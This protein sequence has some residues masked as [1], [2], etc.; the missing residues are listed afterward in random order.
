MFYKYFYISYTYLNKF[1]S[2]NYY[3]YYFQIF[4]NFNLFMKELN[5]YSKNN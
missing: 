1:E 4:L 5:N 3:H 2:L